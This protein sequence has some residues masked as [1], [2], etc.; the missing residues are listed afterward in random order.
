MAYLKYLR[1]D[2]NIRE[3]CSV[4]KY[5]IYALILFVCALLSKTVTCTLPAVLLLIIWWKRDRIKLSDVFMQMPFFI[6]GIA[7]GFMTVW[8]EKYNVGA[9]GE[10]WD[11]SF[12][13]RFL[14]ACRVPCF[15]TG[16]LL[17]PSNLMF[18][19]PRWQI[20][21]HVWQQYLFVAATLGTIGLL[22]FLR[23]RIGSGPLTAVLFFIGTLTPALGLFDVY[24]MQFSF[25]ADHFQYLASIGIITLAAALGC[26][27]VRCIGAS[28]K[29]P[30]YILT[31]LVLATLGS[32]TWRQ[33]H[34]YKDEETLWRDTLAKNSDSW[35]AHV[36]LGVILQGQKEFDKAIGHYQETILLN[37]DYA[38]A[39]CNIANIL[40]MRD[41]VDE[42][43]EFY[44]KALQYDPEYVKAHSNLAAAYQRQKRFDDAIDH[45]NTA[46]ELMG[47]YV[48]A[49]AYNNLGNTYRLMGQFERAVY[50]FE[51]ALKID[52]ENTT[53][54]NNLNKAL[55]QQGKPA[56]QP[57]GW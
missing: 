38:K 19:Y 3:Q 20:D 34:I 23:R 7:F 37:P 40:L 57:S 31:V 28:A 56:Q 12:I 2:D 48:S 51:E 11:M 6:I 10:D 18:T 46:V 50:Y 4:K 39:Y 41:Q 52:P 9:I 5:Y 54:R 26:S 55:L 30:A 14:V 43:I 17:C 29:V 47:E 32:L 25:V 49:A 8:M 21:P 22:W 13:E 36:N 33:C 45:F 1:I 27:V 15:Y 42:A 35:M 24:P 44:L 53:I 16:K